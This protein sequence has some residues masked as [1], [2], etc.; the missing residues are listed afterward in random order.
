MFLLLIFDSVFAATHVVANGCLGTEREPD[1]VP[2]KA[3]ALNPS[4]L[5]IG[6]R[7]ETGCQ[8]R[9]QIRSLTSPFLCWD[10]VLPSVPS[11]AFD[12]AE[13]AYTRI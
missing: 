9:M 3:F 4:L 8:W 7:A 12:L 1:M 6:G 5:G 10:F 11:F 13:H 2:S